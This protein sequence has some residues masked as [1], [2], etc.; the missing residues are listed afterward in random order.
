MRRGGRRGR[1]ECHLGR[2][3]SNVLD[4]K[5]ASTAWRPSRRSASWR[6]STR[7][8]S[9]CATSTRTSTSSRQTSGSAATRWAARTSRPGR[10]RRCATS[11]PAPR[12]IWASTSSSSRTADHAT[13]VVYSKNEHECGPEWVDHADAV[14]GRLR[15]HRRAVVLPPPAAL[16]LV[17][18][19]PQQAARRRHE[20]ALAGSRALPGHLP[21]LFP[22]WK[23]FWAERPDKDTLPEVAPPAPLEK[24]LE[25]MRC[26][27]PAPKIRVR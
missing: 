2:V 1:D 3:A 23:E 17:R 7:C 12:T 5:S 16:L 25:T 22:S 26:G 18:E 10:T 13:G 27:T 15:A 14:L 24:F 21:R 6:R 9:T 8:R 4:S 11:S 20:D 19:R